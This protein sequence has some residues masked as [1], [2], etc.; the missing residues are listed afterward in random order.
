MKLFIYEH[1]P[2]CLRTRMISGLKNLNMQYQVI[3]EGDA[4]TPIS[5]VGKKV[6]PI[7][8]KDNGEYLIESLDIVK[9]LDEL[10]KPR[11]A[12]ESKNN[13]VDEWIKDTANDIFYLVVP[14]FTKGNFKELS[15]PEARQAYLDRETQAFGDIEVLIANTEQYLAPVNQQLQLLEPII[16]E[17][18]G[19]DIDDFKLLP[20]LRSLTIVKDIEFGS[21]T[22]AYIE[23][24]SDKA[25]IDLL[26]D[27]AI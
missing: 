7:L 27:Q 9:Y 12:T 1:C 13:K 16:A 3:M 8:Q 10:D 2:F 21:Q 18:Q 17:R 25:Q 22:Q 19:I 11:F 14:R 4:E 5:M 23:N 15:T 6:V 26:Y 24:L 20:L